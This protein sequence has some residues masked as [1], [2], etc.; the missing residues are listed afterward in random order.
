MVLATMLL[1]YF[2]RDPIG[3]LRRRRRLP[4]GLLELLERALDRDPRRRHRDAVEML[5]ALRRVERR[6][7]RRRARTKGGARR[8]A[9]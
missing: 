1:G 2:S 7:E 3:Q 4:P 9:A 5:D 8:A 6:I